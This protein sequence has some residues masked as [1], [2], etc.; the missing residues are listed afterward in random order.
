MI[1][2]IA[3]MI[4]CYS[5]YVITIIQAKSYSSERVVIPQDPPSERFEFSYRVTMEMWR[6]PFRTKP[7]PAKNTMTGYLRMQAAYFLAHCASGIERLQTH[8][9]CAMGKI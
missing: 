9:G 3:R 6:T 2:E 5:S 7:S 1:H 8:G 4:T